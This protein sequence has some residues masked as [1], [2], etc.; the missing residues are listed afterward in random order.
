MINVLVKETEL[1][2]T[3]LTMHRGKEQ[4]SASLMAK[5]FLFINALQFALIWFG[6]MWLGSVLVRTEG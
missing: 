2:S 6:Q 1:Q 4:R 3:I 5:S